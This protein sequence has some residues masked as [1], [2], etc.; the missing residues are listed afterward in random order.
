MNIVW[1]WHVFYFQ[2][3]PNGALLANERMRCPRVKQYG[4]G[5]IVYRKHT[6]HHWSSL[7]NT[8]EGGVV[9]LPRL[10]MSHIL[11]LALLTG[12]LAL[13]WWHRAV[14]CKVTK[15]STVVARKQIG[16]H[17]RLLHP[18]L[19]LTLLRNRRPD[20]P[21][22]RCVLRWPIPPLLL[23][24]VLKGG[25]LWARLHQTKSLWG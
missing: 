15:L 1:I 22:W 4:D 10:E 5:M 7:R 11:L 2:S 25:S 13:L 12:L 3:Q 24:L 14:P 21:L 23:W 6:R 8:L 9:H 20:C 16:A 18:Y 17:P 19:L